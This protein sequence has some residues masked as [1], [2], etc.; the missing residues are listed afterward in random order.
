MQLFISDIA[1]RRCCTGNRNLICLL[2]TLHLPDRFQPDKE[3]DIVG[4]IGKSAVFEISDGPHLHFE[5]SQNGK[6]V[7]P[8]NIIKVQE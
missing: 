4:K 5:I 8:L 7:D 3:G 6:K 1:I 2:A